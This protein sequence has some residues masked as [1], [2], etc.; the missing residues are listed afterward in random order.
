MPRS[1]T[2]TKAAAA[3]RK[4]AAA[5]PA[6][7]RSATI[8]RHNRAPVWQLATVAAALLFGLLGLAVHVFWIVSIV[9]MSVLFGLIAAT[10]RGREVIPEIVAD[11]REIAAEVSG[12][13]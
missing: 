10:I 11:V 6:R 8:V 3:P 4:R 9:L 7:A 2:K 13:S 1:R 12:D 5:T